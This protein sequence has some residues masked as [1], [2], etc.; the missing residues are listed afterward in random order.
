MTGRRE[1][2]G[3]SGPFVLSITLPASD[4]RSD[5][6]RVTPP[7]PSPDYSLVDGIAAASSTSSSL[8]PPRETNFQPTSDHLNKTR[9]RR[10]EE[11]DEEGGRGAHVWSL[12]YPFDRCRSNFW[13]R[14]HSRSSSTRSRQSPRRS[15]SSLDHNLS[16]SR[17]FS[18]S[19]LCVS[20]VQGASALIPKSIQKR[21]RLS[22]ANRELARII[23]NFMLTGEYTSTGWVGR[24][25]EGTLFGLF[26]TQ[27]TRSVRRA[28]THIVIII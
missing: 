2:W 26:D 24:R 21:I 23:A 10:K 5:T 19:I 7:R 20:S 28:R 3:R 11:R 14:D 4:Y 17:S 8:C 15:L 22:D 12:V 13:G 27:V 25:L 9:K 6:F 1:S 16:F 18:R